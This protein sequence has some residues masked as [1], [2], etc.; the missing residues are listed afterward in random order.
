MS[1]VKWYDVVKCI[2]V[3]LVS[4]WFILIKELSSFSINLTHLK[5]NNYFIYPFKIVCSI[6]NY[7]KR[8]RKNYKSILLLK[9]VSH[10]SE[11]NY[12]Q[13]GLSKCNPQDSMLY[14]IKKDK[15]QNY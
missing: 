5:C 10:R 7:Y 9:C 4:L 12:S 6:Y 15:T 8:T 13:Y 3:S 14:L 11:G 2:L 1:L